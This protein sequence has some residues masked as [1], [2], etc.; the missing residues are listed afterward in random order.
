[1]VE[2]ADRILSQTQ[3]KELGNIGKLL[4]DILAKAR[5][6][7]SGDPQ[8]QRRPADPPVLLDGGAD[9]RFSSQFQDVASQIDRSTIEPRLQ[10]RGAAARHRAA[11]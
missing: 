4:T 5:G 6:T 7:R 2:F 9:P 10:Q 8:G 11:R 3:N 1:V